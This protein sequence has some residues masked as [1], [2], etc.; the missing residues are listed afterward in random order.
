MKIL[1]LEKFLLCIKISIY[2]VEDTLYIC[3]AKML[4]MQTM[5]A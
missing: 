4:T 1:S 2:G 5:H 3:V